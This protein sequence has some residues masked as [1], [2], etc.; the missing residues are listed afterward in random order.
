MIGEHST[1]RKRGY[2]FN[3]YDILAKSFPGMALLVGLGTLL[4]RA[5]DFS[6]Q[7]P[8]IANFA[9]FL[10]ITVLLGLL[11]GEA[12]H[13][14]AETI[15]KTIFYPVRKLKVTLKKLL[16]IIFDT[17]GI[18]QQF[19]EKSKQKVT[20]GGVSSEVVA[21][22]TIFIWRLNLIFKQ[23]RLL[24]VDLIKENYTDFFGVWETNRKREFFDDFKIVIEEEHE[25]DITQ[26]AESLRHLY[27][28]LLSS[29]Y[30][31]DAMLSKRFQI[32]YA[33]CRSMWMTFLILTLSYS[34]VIWWGKPGKF[35]LPLGATYEPIGI[36]LLSFF[37]QGAFPQYIIPMFT[38]LATVGFMVACGKYKFHYIE[39]IIADYTKITNVQELDTAQSKITESDRWRSDV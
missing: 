24:F 28:G 38:G 29:L 14:L 10:V 11:F 32:V 35:S 7:Q 2:V 37:G 23:H 20:N 17:V 33:F 19:R 18:E 22:T 26:E 39:Y 5:I 16:G 31:S 21:I 13:T 1:L 3:G 8:F 36:A 6:F 27:P 25:V 30:M 12:V 9:V 15:E 4:P 34:Y